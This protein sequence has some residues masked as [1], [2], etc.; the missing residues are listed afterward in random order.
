M[1]GKIGIIDLTTGDVL[2]ADSLEE[3][4]RIRQMFDILGKKHETLPP[5]K[6]SDGKENL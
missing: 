1:I 2:W 4:N 5:K 3:A 6:E